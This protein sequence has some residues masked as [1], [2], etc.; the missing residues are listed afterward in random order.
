MIGRT[1]PAAMGGGV[2]GD[3]AAGDEVGEG[4][5]NPDPSAPRRW[6]PSRD[7]VGLLL[8]VVV[9]GRGFG[10]GPAPWYLFIVGIGNT[11]SVPK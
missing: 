9:A 1:S 3:A 10:G 6:G 5:V 4:G 2:G 11:T 8:C 7:M